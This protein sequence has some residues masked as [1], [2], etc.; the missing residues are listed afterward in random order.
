MDLKRAIPGRRRRALAAWQAS[1]DTPHRDSVCNAP[2][3]NMYFCVDGQVAPC[4]LYYPMRPPRWGPDRSILDIWNGPEFTK[5]RRALADGRFLGRCG[6]C[7]HDILTGNRPL[8]AAYDNEHPIGAWPTMLELELSNQCN[9]ECI[10]CSGRLSSKIRRNREG[11]P[12]LVGPYDDTFVDQVAELLPHLH[13]LRFN[14][15]EPLM[16]PIVH[17]IGERV[18]DVRPDLKVTIATNGTIINAKARR[19]LE[20]CNIHVNIS[21]DSLLPERYEAI[22]VHGDF[23]QLMVNFDEYRDYCHAGGRNLAV[24]VNPMRVNWDEMA[25]YV[26]W[27]TE[28]GAHL[29]FN[30]IRY[31]A[32]LALH[33][34]PAGELAHIHDALAAEPLPEPADGPEGD[35]CRGNR[36][37]FERFVH[38]QLAT[39]RDEANGDPQPVRVSAVPVSLTA[40]PPKAASSA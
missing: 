30:T 23:R 1:R 40:R 25:H 3:T 39:W 5:V 24:M 2:S 8:A 22:R 36:G 27:A 29:W 26:W 35:L 14:G 18:G 31:P 16:Q 12:P 17:A 37:V 7:E 34:L 6:T 21:I 19:L 33:N 10:M 4:W 15:G 38:H 20:R 13:E 9:L 11:L 32:D 28:Q